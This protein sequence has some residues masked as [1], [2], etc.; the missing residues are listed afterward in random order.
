MGEVG[1]SGE[2]GWKGR[3]CREEEMDDGPRLAYSKGHTPARA[4]PRPSLPGAPPRHSQSLLPFRR[5]PS[6]ACQML[7][8]S[9]D[10]ARLSL[11][12]NLR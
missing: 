8:P 2:C 3:R 11:T 1:R 4:S 12:R 5:R 6:A 7:G 10:A 9:N